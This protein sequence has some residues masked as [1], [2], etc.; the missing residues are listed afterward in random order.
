MKLTPPDLE[1]TLQ[2][3]QSEAGWKGFSFNE[4]QPESKINHHFV[5]LPLDEDF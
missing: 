5:S 4:T 3:Q 2:D 1:E